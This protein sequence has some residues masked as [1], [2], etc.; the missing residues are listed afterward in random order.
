MAEKYLLI[1]GT[2]LQCRVMLHL[3][4]TQIKIIL[5]R[6]ANSSGSLVPTRNTEANTSP[7]QAKMIAII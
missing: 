4:L 5:T 3:P 7:T 6:K 1:C 2:E